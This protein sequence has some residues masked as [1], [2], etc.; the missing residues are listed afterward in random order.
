[1]EIELVPEPGDG[2]PAAEA[3]RD[4]VARQG[5]ADD[6]RPTTLD[7]RWRR[8][9]LAESLERELVLEPRSSRP[10]GGARR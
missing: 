7:S 2:D 3:A 6:D 4:A 1:M 9:G 10:S 5:L 8:A